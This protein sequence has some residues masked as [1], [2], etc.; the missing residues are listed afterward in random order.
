[1]PFV[2]SQVDDALAKVHTI[3]PE[4]RSAFSN[5]LKHLQKLGFPGGINTGRGRA[6]EYRGHHIFLLG[7]ALQLIELGLNPERAIRVVEENLQPITAAARLCLSNLRRDVEAYETDSNVIFLR[8]DPANLNDLRN[9]H[10][11]GASVS[12]WYAGRG[13]LNDFFDTMGTLWP[14]LAL[15]NLSSL[16]SHTHTALGM[17][18]AGAASDF[19]HE[20]DA[21]LETHPEEYDGDS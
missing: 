1:M 4:K 9:R 10:S 19:E 13:T 2:F 3:V 20:L 12:L 14:R 11:D 8:F 15:I 16:I 6:A 21:W 7:V 5:R 18:S 17:V